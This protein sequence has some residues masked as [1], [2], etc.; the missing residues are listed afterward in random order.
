[1]Y[2]A[3]KVVATVADLCAP[4]VAESALPGTGLEMSWL[5][6]DDSDMPE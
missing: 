3:C 2:Q 1:M 5:A 6:D 4:F